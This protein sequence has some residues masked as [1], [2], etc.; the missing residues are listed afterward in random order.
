MSDQLKLVTASKKRR[1]LSSIY[2]ALPPEEQILVQF[3]SLAMEPMSMATVIR[4]F[5]VTG[6]PFAG[7]GKTSWQNL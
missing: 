4:C 5:D 2:D 1:Q 7:T 6:I 3:C